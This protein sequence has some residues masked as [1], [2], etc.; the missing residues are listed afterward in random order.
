MTVLLLNTGSLAAPPTGAGFSAAEDACARG[1]W[2]EAHKLYE[3]IS[4]RTL[5][6]DEQRWVTFRLA[7]T[8][9][10]AMSGAR[11]TDESAYDGY[12]RSL[13]RLIEDHYTR[14]PDRDL[15]YALA[16]ESLGDFW[17]SAL[18]RRHANW[19]AAQPWYQRAFEYWA[20]ST[21]VD[22]ARERYLG[23]VNKVYDVL[24]ARNWHWN[25][26]LS[27]AI[28]A[29]A[30][31]IAVDDRDI[32]RMSYLYA[33]ATSSRGQTYVLNR[34]TIE[35]YEEA[36][37]KGRGTEWYDDALYNYARFMLYTGRVEV[38]DEG[39]VAAKP[40]YVRAV[41]LFERLT[42]TYDRGESRFWDEA[43][44]QIREI[45]GKTIDLRV[46]Q[47]Y[48]PGSD[49]RLH[50]HW[51]NVDRVSV[52][53]YPTDLTADIRPTRDHGVD[54]WLQSIEVSGVA[55]VRTWDIETEDRGDH[56]PGH[57]VV[58]IEDP[59]AP[60][61]YVVVGPDDQRELLL[62]SDLVIVQKSSPE[63]MLVYVCNA[64]T[65]APVP[66]AEVALFSHIRERD[67]YRI[68]D[69][70]TGRT[71]AQ[72]IVMLDMT[73]D[74]QRG[75]QVTSFVAARSGDRQA[76]HYS[77]R[78]H[79]TP[80]ND[81]WR[82][83]AYTDRPAYRPGETVEWRFVARQQGETYSTPEGEKIRY[84]IDNPNG[85]KMI[86]DTVELD[87]FGTAHAS[88]DVTSEMMLGEYRVRFYKHGSTDTI[89]YATLFRLEEY[90]LPEFLVR[91]EPP[92]D[93][94]GKLRPSVMGERVEVDMVAEYYFGGPVAG[95]EVEVVIHQRP[96]YHWWSPRREYDWYFEDANARSS[97]GRGWGWQGEQVSREQ[98]RTDEEGRVRI[99]FETPANSDYDLTYTIECRVTDASRR[100]I[101]SS[102][103][104]QV[105]RQSYFVYP[106]V[107][108]C[109]R[110][111][112]DAMEV[113]FRAVDANDNPIQDRGKVR[114]ERL[115]WKEIWR[116]PDGT[117]ITGREYSELK[118][119]GGLSPFWQP[120]FI[121]YESEEIALL[122]VET[123]DEGLATVTHVA[124]REGYYRF[125]WISRDPGRGLIQ[126]SASIWVADE[127]TEFLGYHHDGVDVIVD[128]DSFRE[129]ERAPVMITA[130]S[131]RRHVLFTV[132]SE[133]ILS[134]EV[135]R[136]EGTAKLTHIDLTEAHVPNT[137][138]SAYLVAD[139]RVTSDS[140]QVVVPPVKHFLDV[141]VTADAEAY[142]PQAEGSLL[143]KTSDYEGRPV[144]ASVSVAL[145]DDSVFAIQSDY[146][147]D[148]RQFFYGQKRQN[149]VNSSTSFG[150]RQYGM[151]DRKEEEAEADRR[152]AGKAGRDRGLFDD[153]RSVNAR[154]GITRSA[155][156]DGL[157]AGAEIMESESLSRRDQAD[158]APA[159]A[160]AGE[161][162][163]PNVQVRS[164]F[165]ST[166]VWLP[167]VQTDERGEAHVKV[168][169]PD[170]LTRWRA[171]ARAVTRGTDVGAG[172]AEV[173]TILPVTAR[174]QAPR[175]FV[176]GDEVMI[177]TIINNNTDEAIVVDAALAVDGVE[178]TTPERHAAIEIA[179]RGEY[180]VDW[181]IDA[182]E[183]GEAM[184]R[185]TVVS[186][187]GERYSDAME[188]T[189]PIYEHGIDK[190]IAQSG[191]TSALESLI[192]LDLPSA[193][194]EGSTELAVQVTPSIAV[195]MLD[196]LPYLVRYPYGCTEQTMSRF[197]PVVITARTLGD[198]GLSREDVAS[199]IF[200][201]IEPEHRPKAEVSMAEMDEVIRV[202]LAR[203]AD[204]QQGDG[205]WGWWKTDSSNRYMTAYVVWGLSLAADADLDFDHAMLERGVGYLQGQLVE[206]EHRPTEQAWTL[207]AMSQARRHLDGNP[208]RF[209]KAAL[210]NLWNGRD[211]LN[212]FGQ[213]LAS[214]IF[215]HYGEPDRARDMIGRLVSSAEVDQ[216]PDRSAVMRE[217]VR[218]SPHVVQTARW[219]AAGFWYRWFDS[220]IE[221]T[222]FA[223]MALATVEPEHELVDA[224][225][226]W[227]VKNRRGAR[228]TNTR[229][230]AIVV[231][232]LN[233]YLRA[234]GETLRTVSYTV[235]VNGE[236]IARR[237]LKPA[238]IIA[239]PATFAVDP[240]LIRDHNEIRIEASY[241]DGTAAPLY[242]MVSGSFF[243]LEEPITAAGHEMF[244]RR[245]YYRMVPRPTLLRGFV[246]ERVPLNDGDFV[247]SGER[248]E[249]VVSIEVKN[250][251]SYLLIE[252]L[253]PAGLEAVE[254]KSGRGISARQLTAGAARLRFGTAQAK[255]EAEA[256]WQAGE[257][258]TDYT[259]RQRSTYR[260]L[261]DR[262]V[263]FFINS[264]DQGFWE[265]TYTL[266]AEVPGS[267]HALPVKGEAMYAPEIKCNGRE[268]RLR[269]LD[270]E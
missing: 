57:S 129:G 92:R 121:G 169:F 239:A 42:R 113:E 201:G 41:E 240:E 188:K 253:K 125:T 126:A 55:P 233:Q 211:Q 50:V 204:T 7:D 249:V 238:D 163:V 208:S 184:L 220:P 97:F 22:E 46:D 144:A 171:T 70:R 130:P 219:G 143:V 128:K 84:R 18:N 11:R 243:S 266:R 17:W 6:D 168:N 118:R 261:R 114:V 242:Y 5:T 86:E 36:I 151:W 63:R 218:E 236:Q 94:D 178:R 225:M 60:G 139:A 244:I 222:S 19:G 198:M 93:D 149:L 66:D 212:A 61:A 68:Q 200:G 82:I 192:R 210:E 122:D 88:L 226:M 235:S 197:L 72:G 108:H 77:G 51:R 15:A 221:T 119:R 116:L 174:L 104:V 64:L 193:R 21:D 247:R 47:V 181:M 196:A 65:G 265:L 267:F 147:G 154:L 185:T 153:D 256:E 227:L 186:V 53:L 258:R 10:R 183:A 75:R 203:L 217:A 189:Y 99:G 166:V 56:H 191:R 90:K 83:Y 141:Q 164:D 62:V 175:F 158:F 199:G 43:R 32:A 4:Q 230:T 177:S 136:M 187:S 79:G 140:E 155:V 30:R 95:A 190:L 131:S 89:G 231:M 270:R 71:D 263:A 228:W 34:R 179:A 257:D 103:A 213:S 214:L 13:E 33:S 112:G 161:V 59:L 248:I 150:W 146:A 251:Y 81:P 133:S 172:T 170:N 28:L 39:Y 67:H 124:G 120:K 232:A 165:R 3:S 215:H 25:A 180:R 8:G 85:E 234:S 176:V 96:F 49:Q 216:S 173:R 252:D 58:N 268:V 37:A 123:D 206:D 40:D 48:L 260:E 16:A 87:A 148:P 1:A 255:A 80:N 27:D 138:I 24:E 250:D 224:A 29:D 100:E 110:A 202:S 78:W 76:L 159:A 74:G 152:N 157:S 223:L 182:R 246:E 137:W 135:I 69:R 142:E 167:A 156:T 117:E 9:W 229:D 35:A 194:Q 38:T 106:T 264:L 162:G 259:G 105:T 109:I 54:H 145:V 23:I 102:Q 31:E 195:T 45:T 101:T 98:L 107:E 254:V 115:E 132:E 209:E 73:V 26:L 111:P 127:S 14:E 2:S 91:I 241:D 237:T 44:N 262:H 205:G 160:P 207:H 20:N 52:K 269:V 12:R 134:Y 245:Q